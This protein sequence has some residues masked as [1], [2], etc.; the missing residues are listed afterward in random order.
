M[1]TTKAYQPWSNESRSRLLAG[2][3]TDTIIMHILIVS[4]HGNGYLGDF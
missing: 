3:L 1:I 2:L 4:V